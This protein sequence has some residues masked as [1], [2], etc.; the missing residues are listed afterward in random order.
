MNMYPKIIINNRSHAS[1]Y[2]HHF[3]EFS[4]SRQA[5]QTQRF[6]IKFVKKVQNLTF[7]V[8]YLY[9]D[10]SKSFQFLC[11]I[12]NDILGAYFLLKLFFYNSNFWN[13]LFSIIMPNFWRTVIH[14]MQVYLRFWASSIVLWNLQK[15]AINVRSYLYNTLMSFLFSWQAWQTQRFCIKLSMDTECKYLRDVPVRSTT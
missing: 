9:Q 3:N 2:S 13:N 10:S 7:K 4:I 15:C 6:C 14:F 8:N 11:S 1:T 12:E 5:W